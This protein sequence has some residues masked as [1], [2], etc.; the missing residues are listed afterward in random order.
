MD[1]INPVECDGGKLKTI[2]LRVGGTP[3]MNEPTAIINGERIE[4]L[5]LER[6]SSEFLETLLENSKKLYA[7]PNMV[8]VQCLIKMELMIRGYDGKT[9]N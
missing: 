2:G 6:Y 8:S 3:I 9:R 1:Y 4:F 5:K 7:D